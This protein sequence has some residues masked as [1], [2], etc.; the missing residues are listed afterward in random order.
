MKRWPEKDEQ[1]RL[2]HAG[3]IQR[4][5]REVANPGSVPDLEQI[6]KL[7]EENEWKDLVAAIR[8]ILAGERELTALGPLDEEDR[9]IVESILQGI[10][11][12]DTLPD[13]KQAA[14]PTFAAPALAGLVHAARNG[15]VQALQML[16]NLATQMLAAG[17][18]MARIA[19]ILRP[20]VEGERDANRLSEKMGQQAAELVDAIVRELGRLENH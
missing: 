19:G 8:R 15:D 2:A 13:P 11:N 4:V 5:V 6:L 1:I 7:S 12:P 3:L 17:G 9:V 18:D 14:D 20:L 16:G 10:Q